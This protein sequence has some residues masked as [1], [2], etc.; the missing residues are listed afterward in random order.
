MPCLSR[1]TALKI[2]SRQAG[3]HP[4][5]KHSQ[6]W[7]GPARFGAAVLRGS[8]GGHVG[9]AGTGPCH[10]AV[11]SHKG[12]RKE[13]RLYSVSGH[14]ATVMLAGQKGSA[15]ISK[16][17]HQW[18]IAKVA[19]AYWNPRGGRA[20]EPDPP[21]PQDRCSSKQPRACP[22][23]CCSAAHPWLNWTES[24]SSILVC[25]TDPHGAG[26]FPPHAPTAH[27]HQVRGTA[28]EVSQKEEDGSKPW[29]E[30]SWGNSPTNSLSSFTRVARSTWIASTKQTFSLPLQTIFECACGECSRKAQWAKPSP[31][32]KG[33]TKPTPW[34][35]PELCFCH[36]KGT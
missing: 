33:S 12:S 14:A 32:Q 11:C 28:I 29:K 10:R 35:V 8:E 7:R 19:A 18:Q 23:Q 26:V 9:P 25:E 4:C 22:S 16:G 34:A 13:V 2:T 36:V 6:G 5:T 27:R 3:G 21:Q 20:E 30:S 17:R 24:A 31:L 15:V 1:G